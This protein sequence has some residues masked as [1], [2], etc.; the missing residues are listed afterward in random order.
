MHVS[1]LFGHLELD[2]FVKYVHWIVSYIFKCS[3]LAFK[4]LLTTQY[5][6]HSRTLAFLILIY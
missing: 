6:G 3:S 5:E 4:H 2:L 1:Y